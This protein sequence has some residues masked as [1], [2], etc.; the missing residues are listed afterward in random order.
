[1]NTQDI[2]KFGVWANIYNDTYPD[3][4]R[5]AQQI[6]R[7]GYSALWVPDPLQQDPFVSLT[8]VAPETDNLFLATGIANIM[9]RSPVAMAATRT[10]LGE[11]SNGRLI[12]GLGVSHPEIISGM[13]R[14]DYRKPVTTMRNYLDAMTPVSVRDNPNQLSA[15]ADKEKFGIVVLAALGNK[16]LELSATRADGAHPYLTTPEHT[17]RAREV[18]GPHSFLAPEQKILMIKDAA[19]ARAVARKHVAIYLGLQNYR[20]N[21]LTLGFNEEDFEQGGS[22]RLIDALVAWGDETTI[23]NRLEAH[24]DNGANHVCIQPLRLDGEHGYDYNAIE[25]FAPG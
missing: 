18:M 5:L 10:S 15:S 8:V 1:M 11:L 3:Q 21:L 4:I 22:D 9:T 16:M 24:L 14:M 20:N 12:L 2:G 7:W 19:T 6:E 17:A 25:V 23:R 13:L